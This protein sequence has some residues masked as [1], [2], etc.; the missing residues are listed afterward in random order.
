MT[1][2]DNAVSPS[3]DGSSLGKHVDQRALDRMEEFQGPGYW[4]MGIARSQDSGGTSY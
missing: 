2:Y 4:L 1:G 3:T